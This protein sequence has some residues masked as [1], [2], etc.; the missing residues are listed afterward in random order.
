[1]EI[2]CKIY[3]ENNNYK[4]GTAADWGWAYLPLNLTIQQGYITPVHIS[5]GTALRDGGGNKLF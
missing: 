2:V 4:V 5:M 1:M 3:D